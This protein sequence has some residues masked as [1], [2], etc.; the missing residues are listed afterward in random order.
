MKNIYN[1]FLLLHMFPVCTH[2]F[3][4]TYW[5]ST[6]STHRLN[7]I[8]NDMCYYQLLH[9]ALKCMHPYENS[10]SALSALPSH[11]C[12]LHS[13]AMIILLLFF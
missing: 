5:L 10:V 3:L 11:R 4:M 8:Q 13:K 6:A 1:C 7:N 9:M 12:T 2:E